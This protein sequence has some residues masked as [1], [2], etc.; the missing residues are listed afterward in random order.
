MLKPLVFFRK[1]RL[2]GLLS[3]LCFSFSVQPCQAE[4]HGGGLI[5]YD[6]GS[7]WLDTSG[8]NQSLS[9]DG[10]SDLG[11]VY[12]SQG[13]GVHAIF[14]NF[15]VGL[16]YQSLLGQVSQS[17]QESLKLS[18]HYFLLDAGYVV[19]GT[20]AFQLYS[21]VGTGLG[22]VQLNSSRSLSEVLDLSQGSNPYLGQI[23]SQDWLVDLGLGANVILPM[24]P[25]NASDARGPALSLRA[26]YLWQP[27]AS[28]WQAQELPVTGDPGISSGGFYLRLALGFGGYR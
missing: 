23:S 8:L 12:F 28:Q 11:S 10:Y 21:Y 2:L 14:R 26:G 24:S 18:A 4:E 6:L 27:L 19:L 22:Q 25:N 9:Q 20:P 13:G 15:L 1:F 5:Y 16:E 3:A 7:Q 17:S